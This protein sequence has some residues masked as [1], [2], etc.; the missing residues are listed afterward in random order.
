MPNCSQNNSGCGCGGTPLVT[1]T[2]CVSTGD[3]AKEPC[4]ELFCEECIVHC[5]PEIS[6]VLSETE[7][8][9]IN[10]GDRFDEIIQKLMIQLRS[11]DCLSSAAIGLR[12]ISKTSTSITISWKIVAGF[13]YTLEWVKGATIYTQNVEDLTQYQILN[14]SADTEYQIKLICNETDC[15]SV[16]IKIK[17]NI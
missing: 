5:Q 4:S 1:G 3:C 14:L 11:A 17:T 6:V 9:T 8:F 15:E 10:N 7:T 13:T 2:P 16:I 12:L